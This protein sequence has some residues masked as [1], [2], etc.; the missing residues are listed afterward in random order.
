MDRERVVI[1]HIESP[2]RILPLSSI[3]S[4]YLFIFEVQG[5]PLIYKENFIRYIYR[6]NY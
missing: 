1:R 2:R 6:Y 4:A 5:L 3:L